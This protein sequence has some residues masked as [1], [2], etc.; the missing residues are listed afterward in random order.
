MDLKARVHQWLRPYLFLLPAA[1][2]VAVFVV[3]PLVTGVRLSLENASSLQGGP[4]VGASNF[5]AV[6][7]SGLFQTALVNNLEFFGGS[8]LLLTPVAFVLALCLYS[9]RSV[10][11]GVVRLVL[12]LPMSA[13]AVVV[14]VIFTQL[15][16]TQFGLYNL[17]LRELGLGA[18]PWVTSPS[19][20]M[21]SLIILAMWG[22]MGLNV[23]YVL[24]GLRGISTETLEAARVDGANYVRTV[25]SII[26]PQLR[27]ILVFVGVQ[28][29]VGSVNLFAI[30]M[31][32]TNGGPD[33]RSFTVIMYIY[34]QALDNF[35]LGTAAAAG[36]LVMAAI[37]AASG[38]VLL[39][40]SLEHRW[41][42]MGE[43]RA[44]RRL[45]SVRLP[46]GGRLVLG[47]SG[48]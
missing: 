14:G 29:I 37:I 7:G 26:V 42:Y 12:L 4:F 27:S 41:L 44:S 30:P 40:G 23:A 34:Q 33:N 31:V 6:L 1:V 25:R 36:F 16:S 9:K 5:A 3:Y 19:V 11:K 22:Y 35:S 46:G 10:L 17:W 38:L 20:V 47:R 32:L 2:F 13:S 45:P 8:I 28:A 21:V 43:N 48:S 18:V 24:A 15:M 39:A